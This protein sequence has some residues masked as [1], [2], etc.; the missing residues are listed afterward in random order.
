MAKILV[1]EDALESARLSQRI[2]V[3]QDY[4]VVL[5]ATGE[6]GIDRAKEHHPNMILFDLGLPDCEPEIVAQ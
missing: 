3:N 5:A 2:L 1:I 6:E 4:E